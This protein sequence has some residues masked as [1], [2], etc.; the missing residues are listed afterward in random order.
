MTRLRALE[1]DDLPHVAALFERVMRSGSPVSSAEVVSFFERTLL[2]HPWADADIPSLV[3]TDDGGE[4]TGF[5]GSHV[6]RMRFDGRLIRAA[7]VGHWMSAPE[8]RKRA[9]GVLLLRKYMRGQQDL[10]LTDTAGEETRRMWEGLGGETLHLA[11]VG[12]TRVFRPWHLAGD[13]LRNRSNRGVGTPRDR[14]V[15]SLL[16][17]VTVRLGRK[18]LEPERS[19][20][21]AETLTAEGLVEQLP[22]VTAGL[23]LYPDYDAGYLQWLFRELDR[24]T[25]HGSLVRYLV[26]DGDRVL[27]WYVYFLQPGSVSRVLQVAASD[28]DVDPVLDHLFDHA[29]RGGAAA[30]DGRVEPRLLEPLSRRHC[31]LRYIGGAMMHSRGPELLGAMVSR[32]TLLTRMDGEWWATPPNPEA[33]AGAR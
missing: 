7:Y 10:T 23:R 20:L 22:A 4:I 19:T 5:L 11:D 6:R 32:H 3:A 18:I 21:T 24:A 27:G 28:K 31:I 15:S 13:R 33:R 17:S 9:V 1:R 26:R 25:H 8:T 14:P 2:D 12:W 30:L 16:D 29:Y